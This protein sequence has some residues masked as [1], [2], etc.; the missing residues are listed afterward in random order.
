MALQTS[1]AISLNDIAGEFGGSVPH[2]ITEYYRGGGLV[3]N[4]SANNSIPTS[5]TI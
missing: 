2:S 5:G 4:S 1:G 3:P